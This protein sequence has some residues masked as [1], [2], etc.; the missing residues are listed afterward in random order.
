MPSTYTQN[1]GLEKIATGEQSGTWGGTE[2]TNQDML[3]RA[4]AGVGSITLA[5]AGS[6]GSPNTLDVTDGALSDGQYKFI[7]FVDGGDLGADAYVQ[8]TPNDAQKVGYFRN[9]LSGNRAIYIFQGTYSAARDYVIAN[10]ETAVLKFN[11]GGAGASTATSVLVNASFSGLLLGNNETLSWKN[12]GDTDTLD[13][14]LDGSD[15]LLVVLNSSTILQYDLSLT[16]WD[17]GSGLIATTGAVTVGSLA[18]TGTVTGSNL[19]GTNT[20]DESAAAE[21]TAGVAEIATQAETDAGTDDTRIVTPLKLANYSG[22]GGGVLSPLTTK[23]DIWVYSTL[24]ARLPVGTNGQYLTAD[25]TEATGL[26]WITAPVGGL[27]NV[28]EDTSPELGGDLNGNDFDVLFTNTGTAKGP[29]LYEPSGGGT[30]WL[31]LLAPALGS[32]WTFTFP[33]SGGSQY[34]VLQT[35]GSGNTS[36][37]ATLVPTNL[38]VNGITKHTMNDLGVGTGTENADV[39]AY[40]RFRVDNDGAFTLNFQNVPS[41]IDTELGST[42]SQEGIIVI[43]NGGSAGTITITGLS[44]EIEIGSQVTTS[45]R[46]ILTYIFQRNGS[47]TVETT[48]IWSN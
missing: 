6:S 10:G 7:E 37:T 17:F 33:T 16:K 44:G 36:W 1:L 28:V 2:R 31:Q 11:G 13:V 12:A 34:Q 39:S 18:A 29:K 47:G 30:S 21:G 25:S 26:K 19:S 38:K 41:G 40:D 35:D 46:Q 42:W 43:D 5:A 22:L 23:G 27:N 8:L 14:K 9:S 45:G 32:N 3:D 4:I 24:D 15:D 48:L 20:G